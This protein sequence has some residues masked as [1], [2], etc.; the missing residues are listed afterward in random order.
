MKKNA[1]NG[2]I[3]EILREIGEY[4]EIRGVAFKPRAYEKAAETIESLRE[5]A[6][7][8]YGKGGLKAL[9]DVPGVGLSIAAKIEELLKTGRLRYYEELKKKTP[10]NLAELTRVEG[11]GPA[12]IRR[13]YDELKIKNLADLEKAARA[14][15]IAELEGFGPKSAENILKGI[16]FL[17]KSAG[18]FVL[19][20]AAPLIK[21]IEERLRAVKGVKTVEAA[22]SVRRRKETIGDADF[23]AIAAEP[24]QV[25][26]YF[27]AM[28]EVARVLARGKTKSMVQLKNGLEADIRV[29][30]EE[31]YGAALN[32]FTGSKEHNVKLRELAMKKGL[33]LNEYGLFRLKNGKEEKIAGRTEKEIYEA[34]GLEYIEPELREDGGE[35]EAARAGKLPKLINYGDLKGDLQ[36]QTDWSDGENSIEEMASEARRLGLEY[37]A[38]T[39]HTKRLAMAR[40]LDEKRIVSQMKKI[41]AINAGFEKKGIKLRV[42]KG[43]EC[44]ILKNGRLDLPDEILKKLDVA[45]AAVHSHFNLTSQ[46]Q[47]G[48]I[49]KAMQNPHVDLIFH[50]TGRVINRRSAYELDMEEIV[51]TA[52]ETKTV[53]EIDAFYDRLDLKDVHIRMCVEAGVLLAVDSDA[54]NLSHFAALEYGIAQARRGWATKND[55]INARPLS[56]MLAK[57]K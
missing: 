30:S 57:L 5:E 42:L 56:K 9:E 34:L 11:L 10:V 27:V 14:G 21:T 44:D 29:L 7:D 41:D 46:E 35:I 6:S 36:V 52:R 32:Y 39:D 53:L 2:E 1:S 4:L 49:K 33:K 20:F 17:K 54:H 16:E 25:M 37:I 50:P 28:P 19:G 38:V 51:R 40:G 23:L 48:R 26:N 22:G 43:T 55:V 3:A 31:S 15:K 45:G 12:K 8:I 24:E 18:R 13:L 47:T